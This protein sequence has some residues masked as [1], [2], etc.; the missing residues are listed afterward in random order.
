MQSII[1][2]ELSLK[3]E[4]QKNRVGWDGVRKLNPHIP[5]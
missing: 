3:N 2:I 4:G 5:S 1:M